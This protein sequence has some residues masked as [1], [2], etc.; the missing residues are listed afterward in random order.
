[1]TMKRLFTIVIGLTIG[2]MLMLTS[3][4]DDDVTTESGIQTDKT[5]IS[6]DAAGGQEKVNVIAN[7]EWVA[8]ASEPWITVSPANGSNDMECVI[9]IDST[10][11]TEAREANVRFMLKDGSDG[12]K[13][14]LTQL[15]FGKQIHVDSTSV[16]IEASTNIIS[17]R[18]F[19]V[20]VTA[21]VPFEIYI[22]YP[23]SGGDPKL[24][25]WLSIHEPPI[26]DFESARPYS[27]KLRFDWKIN[28]EWDERTAQI[29][30]NPIKAEDEGAARTPITVTQKA[31]PVITDDRAGDSLALVAIHERLNTD[32]Q[33]DYN[34]N[35]RYW[36]NL[37]LWERNDDLPKD[38]N[39]N[40][41]QEAIGRVRFARFTMFNT[42]ESIPYEVSYLKYAETLSF[43]AN[44]NTMLLNIDLGNEICELKYLKRL[45][46][47]AYGLVSLPDDFVKLG[48]K[49]EVLDLS[50]NNFE[51][52]PSILTQENFPKLKAL[53]LNGNRRWSVVN[54][55]SPYNYTLDE[56]GL[57]INL[58]EKPNALDQLFFW[59]NLESLSLTYNYLEGTL[60]DY[61]DRPAYTYADIAESGDTLTYLVDHKI[62]KILP[63]VKSL[64]LNL[65]FFTG[66]LPDWILYH[67][68]LIEWYPEIFIFNQMETGIDSKGQATKFSNRPTNFEYYFEAFPDYRGKYEY[69]NDE[70]EEE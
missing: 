13:V 53:A 11:I 49:L 67:P 25:N 18:Y 65:N 20:M 51:S 24:S 17:D 3:C 38:E 62:P 66:K 2:L 16:H 61:K 43:D 30:F 37:T 22:T 36:K 58:D 64:G 68:N 28:P 12:K 4:K 52:I 60:P 15:G 7:G 27:Q 9:T 21:N 8:S 56:I 48:D 46:I 39:G 70:E 47:S 14:K 31:A 50:D 26:T 44:A 54:L 32:L 40:P 41:I 34:E 23:T 19:E 10:L 42:K 5:E 55:Q 29:I 1:M 57:H 6:F 45:Q 35:M 63:N 33:V 59:D 69:I